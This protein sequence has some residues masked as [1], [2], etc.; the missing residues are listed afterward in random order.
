[1]NFGIKLR[2]F[3]QAQKAQAETFLLERAY[4]CGD[5]EKTHITTDPYRCPICSSQVR[6]LA[7]VM[8]R[9]EVKA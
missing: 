6:S 5:M 1:M 9:E 8:N 3:K 7:K 4:I 2:R